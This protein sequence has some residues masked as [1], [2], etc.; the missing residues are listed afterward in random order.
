MMPSVM[1]VSHWGGGMVRAVCGIIVFCC[2]E[3]KKWMKS[4]GEELG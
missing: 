4:V 1:P 3:K 2:E